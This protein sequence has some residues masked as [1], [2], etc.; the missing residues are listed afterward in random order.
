MN[1]YAHVMPAMQRDAADVMDDALSR[2]KRFRLLSDC[3]KNAYGHQDGGRTSF[4]YWS[5]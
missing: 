4:I 5:R 1:T 2:R 3:G